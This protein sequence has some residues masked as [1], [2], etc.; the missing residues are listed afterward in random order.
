MFKGLKILGF[1]P[2][3]GGSKGLPGKNIKE[4]C[5][6]PLIAWTVAAARS[7]IYFDR[8]LV[9]TDDPEIARVSQRFG[10]EVPFLRPKYLATDKA[11]TIDAMFHAL[12][13]FEKKNEFFDFIALLEPTSPLR[14]NGDI[15]RGIEKLGNYRQAGAVISIGEVHLEHPS[16]IKRKEGRFLKSYLKSKKKVTRRQD[17]DPAYFPYG[18]LYLTR[19]S[20]LKKEKTIYAQNALYYEIERWQNYEID[21]FVDWLIVEAIL[22]KYQSELCS[23]EEKHG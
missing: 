15:D 7:S 2:A 6:Y 11:K 16:I 4:I 17:L 1:I 14:K 23:P 9:S 8:I 13:F 18:V 10:A 19:V 20:S 21:D 22:E 12:S 5:G 3:R